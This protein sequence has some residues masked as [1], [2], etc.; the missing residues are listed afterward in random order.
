MLLGTFSDDHEGA[1]LGD[2][3]NQASQV[4][5]IRPGRAYNTLL[6]MTKYKMHS[7]KPQRPTIEELGM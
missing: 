7:R 3:S 5:A 4:A 6:V 1:L 2:V